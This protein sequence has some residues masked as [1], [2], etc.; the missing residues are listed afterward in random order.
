MSPHVRTHC[1]GTKTLGVGE[2]YIYITY[3]EFH[4]LGS[5]SPQLP[6]NHHLA[7]LRSALH[8]ETEHTVA[9]SPHR[10]SIEQFIPERFALRDGG[11]TAVLD[12]GG[13]EGDGVFG[14][15]EAFLDEGGQFADAAPLLAKD[16][17]GVCC[18]DD[19]SIVRNRRRRG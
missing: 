19:C 10:E 15:F 12:L 5:R 11:E 17:L 13:V 4:A 2:G 6:R 18:A 7:S 9:R 14:E 16:F 1:S 3:S 8:D